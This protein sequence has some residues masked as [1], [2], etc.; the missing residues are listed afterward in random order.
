[1]KIVDARNDSPARGANRGVSATKGLKSTDS[2]E[3]EKVRES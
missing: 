3:L 2:A 1:M